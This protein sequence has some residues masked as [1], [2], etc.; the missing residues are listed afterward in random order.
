VRRSA[1][2][3]KPNVVSL[4][5]VFQSPR[6]LL[7]RGLCLL[8]VALFASACL[9]DS[10]AAET[11]STF[12]R[13]ALPKVTHENAR[14][15]PV[16]FTKSTP[17]SLD[18]LR[19]MQ[20]RVSS[21]IPQ[22]SSAV[23]AVELTNDD[24]TA[25][26][27]GVVISGDGL[28][29]TAGHVAEWVNHPVI[30]TF[31][32]GRTAKGKTL[33]LNDD[34]DTGLMRITDPGPWPH[35]NVGDMK[36]AHLGDWVLALGHPG[37]FDAKRSLVVRLGRIIRLMP[38]VVQ[39]D[40]TIF[41]GDSGG[42]L[43]D[44]YGRVIGIHTAISTGADDNFHVAI[45]EYFDTWDDLIGPPERSP[46]YCGLT[47]ADSEA[48]CRLIK[49]EKNSPAAKK[50]LLHEGDL[51]VSVGDRRITSAASFGRWLAESTPGETLHLGVKRGSDLLIIPLKLQSQ[52]GPGR[53]K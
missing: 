52:P 7:S 53:T 28:V 8:T 34:A 14:E 11:P 15:L 26:G 12:A 40:C 36:S 45:N 43:F 48:G 19:N 4:M 29:L 42:P 50:G 37:G 27:S 32:D 39:T 9:A 35:A 25:D 30:F 5:P 16:A 20:T 10:P 2:I 3:V 31:P 1:A 21:I 38:G 47:V 18:D 13:P 33:G 44:M 23:V 6:R 24:G 51:L 41:P 49:I 22:L 17:V 46:V